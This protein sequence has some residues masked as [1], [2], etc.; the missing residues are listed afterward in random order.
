MT[1][2]R[3]LS[4]LFASLAFLGLAHTAHAQQDAALA[5]MGNG[6]AAIAEG[7]IITIDLLDVRKN[8]KGQPMLTEVGLPPGLSDVV[9]SL[10]REEIDAVVA[11]LK[12]FN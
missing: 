9:A 3:S 5:R 1:L 8:A 2:K 6:I 4:F 12:A 7:E 11:L 10:T